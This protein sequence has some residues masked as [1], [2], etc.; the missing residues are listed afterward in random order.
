MEARH[1]S[2]VRN[3]NGNGSTVHALYI[4]NYIA[5]YL[6]RYVF[7]TSKEVVVFPSRSYK[8]EAILLITNINNNNIIS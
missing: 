6:D 5:E 1:I 4:Y 7:P 2:R 8:L 3:N